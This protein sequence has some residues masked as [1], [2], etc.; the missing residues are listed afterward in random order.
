MSDDCMTPVVIEAGRRYGIKI[1][2]FQWDPV[3]N[4]DREHPKDLP[5][6][7]SWGPQ[8]RAGFSL[9][10]KYVYA[11]DAEPG[12]VFHEFIHVILG[13]P[14]LKLCEGYLL[15]PFEWT[16][17]QA[18]AREMGADSDYFLREV[19]AYQQVTEVDR[20]RLPNGKRMNSSAF[21]PA[22]RESTW[23]R[24]GV[25]RA[26]RL[27]LLDDVLIP[28]YRYPRWIGSGVASR[29]KFWGTETDHSY[30]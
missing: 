6:D 8:G 28:T 2:W 18:L 11:Y 24:R 17:A 30:V 4:R 29:T 15:M 19:D 7:F 12:D 5:E 1:D 23:W 25:E 16:F 27:G 26:Q 20:Y 9:S 22:E 13:K 3:A 10:Q 21:E 14:G